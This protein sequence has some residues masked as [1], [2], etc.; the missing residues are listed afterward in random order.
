MSVLSLPFRLTGARVLGDAGFEDRPLTIADGR[1]ATGPAPEVDLTGHDIL[2]GIVDLY[3]R[4]PETGT[5]PDPARLGRRL[6]AHGIT[7]AFLAQDW[8][9]QGGARSPEVA[10]AVLA[11]LAL[12]PRG[13]TDLR[14]LLRC[15]T[16]MMDHESALIAVLE[17][18]AVEAV[19]FIDRLSHLPRPA[20]P[21]LR[22]IAENLCCR[23]GEVPRH[24]CNLAHAI[25]RLGLR[26]GSYGDRD[27]MARERL[28]MMGAEICAV[29]TGIDAA[30][31]ARARSNPV[32]LPARGVPAR[33][34]LSGLLDVGAMIAGGLC[35][36]LVSDG[37][38]ESLAAAALYLARTG[39]LPLAGAW[40]LIS[41]RPARIM[42]LSDRGALVT[43]MRADLV[44]V[45]RA[46]GRITATMAAGHW[47]RR[48]C[49]IAL[50]PRAGLARP[51][52]PSAARSRPRA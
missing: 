36:A 32:L 37:A 27:A 1:I 8:S 5:L 2:P 50:T 20:D 47:T 43:G 51:R 28:A 49:E 3:T 41:R 19:L 31:V 42:G 35:D 52:R 15:D 23:S 14:T 21:D 45:Q 17:R 44:V 46:T 11:H 33:P 16:H 26:S 9:W 34:E 4:L 6:A 30:A 7:T 22:R 29:P 13:R 18:Q 38:P 12:R 25:D 10:S 24:L 40:S 48:S 39:A